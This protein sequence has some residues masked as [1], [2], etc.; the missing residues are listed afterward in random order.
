L[1]YDD[2]LE[3]VTLFEVAE[4]MFVSLSVTLDAIVPVQHSLPSDNCPVW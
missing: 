1:E 3:R 2:P 4:P